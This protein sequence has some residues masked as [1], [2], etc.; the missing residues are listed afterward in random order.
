MYRK[1][2]V[3]M[4]RRAWFGQAPADEELAAKFGITEFPAL[5]ISP[6]GPSDPTAASFDWPRYKGRLT[7]AGSIPSLATP[8]NSW[9]SIERLSLIQ[10]VHGF[11]LLRC[12]FARVFACHL[13]CAKRW[14]GVGVS[15]SHELL[16][17]A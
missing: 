7:Y 12:V 17:D 4:D 3:I 13:A 1:L 2:S 9:I 5:V 15:R 8:S 6:P 11:C 16:H 14:G 10:S